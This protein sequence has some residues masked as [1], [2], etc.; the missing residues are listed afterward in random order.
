M[1]IDWLAPYLPAIVVLMF[2][3]GL[4]FAARRAHALGQAGAKRQR[5]LQEQAAE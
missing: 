4:Y 5:E 2:G 3:V 1:R